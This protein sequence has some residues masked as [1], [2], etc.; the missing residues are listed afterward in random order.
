MFGFESVWL[1]EHTVWWR[2][3]GPSWI[4]TANARGQTLIW[5]V[6][7][8][9][10]RQ[11][12]TLEW[13]NRICVTWSCQMFDLFHSVWHG[14]FIRVK[15]PINIRDMTH[16]HMW[17][18][19]FIRVTWRNQ[20]SGATLLYSWYDS[21]VYVP[22]H[23][24]FYMRHATCPWETPVAESHSGVCACACICICVY[25]HACARRMYLQMRESCVCVCVCCGTLDTFPLEPCESSGTLWIFW[26]VQ[27]FCDLGT[28]L[29][30]RMS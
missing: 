10:W 16:W 29:T 5:C 13:L 14:S 21:F 23:L 3:S 7:W 6:F 24:R 4:S 2:R 9:G 22:R 27:L 30:L 8:G 1:G 28:G 12:T 18:D 17:H 19:S 15:W 11:T 25:M 20:M 26:L